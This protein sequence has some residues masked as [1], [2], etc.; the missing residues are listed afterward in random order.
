MK[1][2]NLYLSLLGFIYLLGANSVLAGNLG[3]DLNLTLTPATGGMA[4]AGYVRPQDPVASVFGNP[5]TL[6]QLKGKT[7]FTFGASYL[8]V[9]AHADH[10][11]SVAG[12]PFSADSEA[13]DYLLPNIAVRQRMTNDLVLG[14]GLQVISGLGADFRNATPLAPV[15]ELIVFGANFDVAYDFTPKTTIGA[16]VTLAFGLLEFG[17]VSNTALQETFG[18]RG[19][20]GITHDYGPVMLGLIYNS[21][22]E[23]DFDNVTETS[24]GVFSDI[25]IEQPRE[26]IL[27]LATTSALWPNL[28]IEADVI[29]KNWD[30]A[31][32][33]QDLWQDTYTF[34]LG[35]Q[36][37][38]KKWKLRLGYSY[39]SDLEDDNIGSSVA[40]LTTLN[41]PGGVAPISPPLIQFI[42]ATL[43]QPY[44][45]QQITAGFGYALT[46]NIHF[47]IQ[48]GYAFDGD[49]TIGG[50][51]LEVNE[52]Q[53]GAGFTWTY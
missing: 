16:G 49:R 21:E 38:I 9:D 50:T 27:G 33:Y 4:G 37:K 29:W 25:T 26:I 7:D 13:E 47:D 23:L 45:Q 30:D 14:G 17:L 20:L 51:H 34:A 11:G 42:Q 28:L 53:L 12:A 39:S 22:L 3:S 1:N 19:T 41:T 40:G 35:G 36:Y 31:A 10:D 18:L 6:S 8:N 52:F 44:W 15:V 2:K 5:A 43:T 24:P 32:G 48:T 46:G